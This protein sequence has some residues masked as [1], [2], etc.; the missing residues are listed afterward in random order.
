MIFLQIMFFIVAL[1]LIVVT[2]LQGGKSEGAS[3]AIMGGSL[4]VFSKTKERGPEVIMVK[5]TVVLGILFFTLAILMK[6]LAA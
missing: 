1:L 5:I 6:T 4:N 2:L 3:G